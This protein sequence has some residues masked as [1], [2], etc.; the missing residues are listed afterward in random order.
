MSINRFLKYLMNRYLEEQY[1]GEVVLS[2]PLMLQSKHFLFIYLWLT[3]FDYNFY[4]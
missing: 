3:K 1:S 2:S 4:C